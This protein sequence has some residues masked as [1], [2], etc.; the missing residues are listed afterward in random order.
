MYDAVLTNVGPSFGLNL[1]DSDG[2]KFRQK[3]TCSLMAIN[4]NTI[5]NYTNPLAPV[6][7]GFNPR[8]EL[9][10]DNT[11]LTMIIVGL[12][13]VTYE[14]KVKDPLFNATMLTEVKGL[15]SKG[16]RPIRTLHYQFCYKLASG[17]DECTELGE[18]PLSIFLGNLPPPPNIDFS[19]FPN[20]NEMQKTILRL[21]TTSAYEFNIANV[22]L[23]LLTGFLERTPISK[24]GCPMINAEKQLC[25]MQ[26]M[27][28]SGKVPNRNA[29]VFGLSFIIAFFVLV[30]ILDIFILKFKIYF[31]KFR[32]AL[33]PRIDCW[34]QDGIW[35]LQR[36][37]YEGEGYRS[38]TDLEADIPLTDEK[39]LKDLSIL[40][41][42]GKSPALRG[43][44][45]RDPA[46][47]FGDTCDS[48]STFAPFTIVEAEWGDRDSRAC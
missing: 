2:V 33:S 29:N 1:Q 18:L 34:I 23:D 15:G 39:T 41:L 37:A 9:R 40:W 44:A 20:A 24:E 13:A 25:K 11:T 21:I 19:T 8:P 17:K 27:R 3:M 7:R 16:G 6:P 36:R 38:W 35:Q 48:T 22:A 4:T 5:W 42:P 14:N 47:N 46:V 43:H 28:K 26:K 12:N 10:R 30:A 31:S 45:L 32:A